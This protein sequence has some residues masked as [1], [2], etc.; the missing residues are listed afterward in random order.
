MASLWRNHV[1]VNK[2]SYLRLYVK[3]LDVSV[4]L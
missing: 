2:K 3:V 4:G 1:D